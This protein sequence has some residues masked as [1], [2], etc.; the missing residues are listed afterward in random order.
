MTVRRILIILLL[1]VAVGLGVFALQPPAPPQQAAVAPPPPPPA[2]AR[3]IVAARTLT[4][5][6]LLTEVDLTTAEVRL[7]LPPEAIEAAA[8]A[9]SGTKASATAMP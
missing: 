5:G 6:T 2:V 8:I 3:I 4:P 1:L 9:D 7:P